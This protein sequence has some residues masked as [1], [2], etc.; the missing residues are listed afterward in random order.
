MQQEH[1]YY[2]DYII[3]NG[4]ASSEFAIYGMECC[5]THNSFFFFPTIG[6]RL[7][8]LSHLK[9]KPNTE[10]NVDTR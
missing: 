4:S 6:S 8:I 2:D 7:D 10:K 9:G 3:Y 5:V 1:H